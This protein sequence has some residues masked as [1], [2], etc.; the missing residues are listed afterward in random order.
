M[1]STARVL[2][3]GRVTVPKPV[4]ETLELEHGDVVEVE[5][6]PVKEGSE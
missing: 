6:R 3:N 5:V 1:K 2:K 4:R